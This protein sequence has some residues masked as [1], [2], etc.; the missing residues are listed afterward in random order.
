[1]EWTVV[2]L[3]CYLRFPDMIVLEVTDGSDAD[4]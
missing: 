1:M 2:C 3:R 4:G